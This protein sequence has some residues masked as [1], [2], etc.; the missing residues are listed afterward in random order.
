MQ[1]RYKKLIKLAIGVA[2][3]I[4]PIFLLIFI[5]FSG[6]ID[7]TSVLEFIISPLLIV[8]IL[9][10]VAIILVF[11]A[12]LFK[13]KWRRILWLCSL[14]IAAGLVIFYFIIPYI[15]VNMD[16]NHPDSGWW[17]RGSVAHILPAVSHDRILLKT[18]F[19]RERPIKLMKNK[20]TKQIT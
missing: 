18:S 19:E 12:L 11:E 8:I 20:A 2:I 14:G 3:A 13:K 6:T 5:A 10:Y 17:D 16:P 15:P 1:K 7:I 9:E 4:V